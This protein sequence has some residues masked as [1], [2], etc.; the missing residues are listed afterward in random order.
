MTSHF[1]NLL[2]VCLAVCFGVAGCTK[3]VP[4]FPLS[5]QQVQQLSPTNSTR[6]SFEERGGEIFVSVTDKFDDSHIHKLQPGTLSKQQA[7]EI[8]KQKQ[9]ELE[10]R[11]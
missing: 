7:V 1:T 5:V 6:I 3:N 4:A 9:I 8:L 11:Q 2:A 10:T